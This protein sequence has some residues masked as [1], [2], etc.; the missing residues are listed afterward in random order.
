MEK[1]RFSR[2]W[3]ITGILTGSEYLGY[4]AVEETL[5][6]A[7]ASNCHSPQGLVDWN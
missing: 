4:L 6:R 2:G 3:F 1:S 5:K 7:G